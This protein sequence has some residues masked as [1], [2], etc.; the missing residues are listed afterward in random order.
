MAAHLPDVSVTKHPIHPDEWGSYVEQLRASLGC[1]RAGGGRS[2]RADAGVRLQSR[3]ALECV[4]WTDTGRLVGDQDDLEQLALRE[5]GIELDLDEEQL[6]QTARQNFRT[7]L[8][9]QKSRMVRHARHRG[10]GRPPPARVM[11]F[12]TCAS[13]PGIRRA[14]CEACAHRRGRA[15]ELQITR[16]RG[17]FAARRSP[18]ARPRAVDRA[19]CLRMIFARAARWPCRAGARSSPRS[20]RCAR[21]SAGT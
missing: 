17:A 13:Q 9:Q 1:A 8:T 2:E 12:V 18:R 14:D 21:R 19:A 5:Y 4:V 20:T 6:R 15:G 11:R 10:E 3:S 7:A 16:A